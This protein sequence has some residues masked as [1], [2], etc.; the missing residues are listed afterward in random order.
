MGTF[1]ILLI[2]IIVLTGVFVL[3]V[4]RDDGVAG[5]ILLLLSTAIISLCVYSSDYFYM[6][7]S[8][9]KVVKMQ[10]ICEKF[11]GLSE[12][13]VSEFKCKDGTIIKIDSIKLDP[14]AP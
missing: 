2:A 3:A 13:D 8:N 9:A 4:E 12:F 10:N 1:Y 14:E 11:G 6:T 5:W 7:F